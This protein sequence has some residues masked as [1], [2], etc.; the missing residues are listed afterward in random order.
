[1]TNV[2]ANVNADA[3]LFFMPSTT[4][5]I[6]LRMIF[7]AEADD[8]QTLS[9][10]RVRAHEPRVSERIARRATATATDIYRYTLNIKNVIR[11]RN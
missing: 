6:L 3:K 5:T 8:K 4:L 2:D 10:A 11:Q 9:R 7:D 1:M